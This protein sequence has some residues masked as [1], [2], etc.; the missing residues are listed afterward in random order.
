M[1]GDE[2]LLAETHATLSYGKSYYSD[3]VVRG[4]EI[5]RL[6]C[7]GHGFHH[8]SGIP[9]IANEYYPNITHEG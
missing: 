8:Y 6:A 3:V 4:I 7:G 5:C 1:K 2:S 9:A